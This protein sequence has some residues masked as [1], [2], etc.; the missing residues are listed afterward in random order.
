MS[1][2]M[3]SVKVATNR[4][5]EISRQL[6]YAL[7]SEELNNSEAGLEDLAVVRLS[8]ETTIAGL[9]AVNRT[10]KHLTRLAAT[11]TVLENPR[12]SLAAH[13]KAD[14]EFHSILA[15]AT[16]NRFFPVVLAPIQDRLTDSRLKTIQQFGAHIAHEHHDKILE[17]IRERDPAAA[18]AAMRE[19]LTVNCRHLDA[20]ARKPRVAARPR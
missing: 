17:A 3:A 20:M 5:S 14:A 19:H 10:D 4:V 16:G 7:H 12:R 11:Q 13:V 18:A 1:V 9:A 8:L 15:E 2:K 6:E